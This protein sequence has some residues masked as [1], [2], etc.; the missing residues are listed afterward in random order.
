MTKATSTM[1]NGA[2]S[3]AAVTP[4]AK[5]KTASELLLPDGLSSA[6][7]EQALDFVKLA[8]KTYDWDDNAV[9]ALGFGMF[10]GVD[11]VATYNFFTHAYKVVRNETG[12]KEGNYI[13]W[14]GGTDKGMTVQVIHTLV[15][16]L[17]CSH[18]RRRSHPLF[19]LS[20][21]INIEL[22]LDFTLFEHTETGDMVLAFRG[23]EPLSV[24]DWIQDIA[25]SF[26]AA[27]T[28]EDAVELAK[29]LLEKAT[30]NGKTLRITGHSLG[31]GLA[32]AAA[33]GTG[34]EAIVFNAAGV[35]EDTIKKLSLNVDNESKITNVNVR[36]CFVSDHNKKMDRTTI[37]NNALGI[38]TEQKQFGPQVWLESISDRADF[39]FLPDWTWTVK[40]AESVLNHACQTIAYQLEHKLF[41]S[42]DD[43]SVEHRDKRLKTE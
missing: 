29:T 11:D 12:R 17:A 31:G 42:P 18:F 43:L 25:Q 5:N 19:S 30:Q 36:E 14:W 9:I 27:E 4:D 32:T 33:L 39:K 24:E 38:L 1:T 10:S 23:T 15:E 35:S 16:S 41:A 3:T 21:S 8:A 26:G 2:A 6:K 34:C 20:S 28:Y 40:R 37:G 22:G 7:Y 13:D